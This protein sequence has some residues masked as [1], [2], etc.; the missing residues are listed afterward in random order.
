M[1]SGG[2]G[3]VLTGVIAGLLASAMDP[4]DAAALGVYVHG[5]AGDLASGKV[6]EIS[7]TAVDILDALGPAFSD[8]TDSDG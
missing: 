8:V 4:F 1:A 3:D 6:G 5:R 7:C 2:V